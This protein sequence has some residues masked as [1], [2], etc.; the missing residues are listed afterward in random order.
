MVASADDYVL[1]GST[2]YLDDPR[3]KDLVG[4]GAPYELEQ[5]VVDGVALRTFKNAPDSVVDL[6]NASK[7]HD[8]L[9][10]IVFEDERITFGE[11]RARALSFARE[12]R[13]EFSIKPGDHVAISMRNLPEFVYAFWGVVVNGA[14]VVPLNSWW[15]GSEL[16]YAL[17][18]SGAK[19][20]VTDEERARRLAEVDHNGPVIAARTT[21]GLHGSIAMDTLISG[22]PLAESALASPEPDDLFEIVYTSGTTGH[23]K[24]TLITHRKLIVTLMSGA[25]CLARG[26]LISPRPSPAPKQPAVIIPTPLFHVGGPEMMVSS[27]MGGMKIVLM[28]RWD[29]D[30]AI[31]YHETEGVAGIRGVPTIARDLLYSPRLDPSRLDIASFSSGGAAIA[32]DLPRRALELFGDSIQFMCGYGA[33]ETTNSVAINVG[34]E[35]LSHL[36][37]IGRPTALVDVQVQD[38]NGKALPIGEVGEL[39]FRTIQNSS[40]YLNLP[41]ATAAAFVGGWYHS[42]DVGYIDAEGY[43]YVVDRLKDMVIRGG[44]NVYCA[45]VEA[46]IVEH[47]DVLDVAVIGLPEE[48]MGE[49]VC[50]AVVH[51]PDARITLEELRE[52]TA[53]RIAYFKQPE[54]LFSTEDIPRTATSKT[55]KLTLRNKALDAMDRIERIY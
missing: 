34:D 49:R 11:M 55:D 52:F 32:P 54:A 20:I 50:A 53:S 24:G 10:C 16:S 29:V 46:A 47:P 28:S 4:P 25:L 5:I 3:L 31:E 9:T 44:E 23:P 21:P 39:C 42:G 30:Q 8:Q 33:T 37:S 35:W 6:F 22:E 36:D 13:D 1:N 19:V 14:V 27:V 15:V 12:L 48:H 26:A 40:G 2:L 43:L 17:K 38:E 41:E 45:E 7:T 51:K 18:D